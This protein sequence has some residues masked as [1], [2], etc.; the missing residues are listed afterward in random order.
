MDQCND[1]DEVHVDRKPTDDKN[2][3]KIAALDA[4]LNHN[5]AAIGNVGNG[6]SI[7]GNM[8]GII[9]IGGWNQCRW[10]HGW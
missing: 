2:A 7:G 6:I 9:N 5:V 1:S 3:G 4:G 10:K 8:I